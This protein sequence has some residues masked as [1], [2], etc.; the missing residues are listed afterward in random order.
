[1]M[2]NKGHNS[3]VQRKITGNTTTNI[4]TH[5][6][7]KPNSLDVAELGNYDVLFILSSYTLPVSISLPACLTLTLQL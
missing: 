7:I 3:F 6:S 5:V 4:D 1:M 2:M